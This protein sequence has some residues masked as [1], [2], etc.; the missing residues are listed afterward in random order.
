MKFIKKG[1]RITEGYCLV[2]GEVCHFRCTGVIITCP[3]AT[4][5]CSEVIMA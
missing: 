5:D 2:C 3:E 1:K 4:A